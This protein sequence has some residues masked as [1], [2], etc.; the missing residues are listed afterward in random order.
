MSD[1]DRLALTEIVNQEH[2]KYSKRLNADKFFEVFSAEQVLKNRSYDLASDQISAG[3]IGNGGD[4]GADSIYLIVNNKMVREDTDLTAFKGQQLIIDLVIT[5]S[6]NQASF[7][8]TVVKNF[9]DLADNCLKLSADLNAVSRKLYKQALLDVIQR[10]HT[11]YRNALSD[12]PKLSIAFYY[13]SL[14]EHIDGKVQVRADALRTRLSEF[15]S[16]AEC[17]VEFAGAKKLLDW[18]YITPP[19]SITLETLKYIPGPKPGKSYVALV[20]LSKFYEFITT[21][22]KLQERIFEANVRDYQGEVQV[23]KD[24]SAT[25]AGTV[26]EDF[27][28]LNNGITI[29]ASEI[30]GDGDFLTITDTLIVN[31][32]Q[33]SYELYN[34]FKDSKTSDTRTI[35][36]RVIESK[37]PNATDRIIKATNNQTKIP[38]MWL[39][40]T[41]DIHRGIEAALAKVGLFYDRRKN[42]YRNQGASPSQIVTIPY[43]SQALVAIVLQRPDDARARPTTAAERHYK[44]LFSDGQPKVI[45][46]KCALI[47]K[48]VD[49]Y[50]DGVGMQNSEASNIRFYLAMYAV[51]AALRS[52]HPR[53]TTIA[54]FNVDLLTDQFLSNCEEQVWPDYQALGGDD[55]IAKGPDLLEL[56]HQRLQVRFGRIKDTAANK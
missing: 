55:V 51:C 41:E 39:H 7:G 34:H 50:L 8:E 42:Y 11:I 25:L 22:D 32:L 19:K 53:R 17:S 16:K 12:K 5:Q 10:F 47:M 30:R 38:R 49:E 20:T 44:K 24:I 2:T 6:K 13:A 35:L 29:V 46:S 3:V 21:N 33:T 48:R 43:L 23:N 37:D 18:F 28:W 26:P 31:G 45:Y 52:I 9:Q 54:A 14:G 27:W 1:E 4:G 36:V 56:I 40:A 15:F